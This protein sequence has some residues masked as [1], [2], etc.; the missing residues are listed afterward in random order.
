MTPRLGKYELCRKIG[1]GGMG[2]VWE[3]HDTVLDRRVALK[4]LEADTTDGAEYIREAK[5]AAKVNHPNVVTVH[6]VSQADG[7]WFIVMEYV[8]G[9]SAGQLVSQRGAILWQEATRIIRDAAAGLAAIHATGMIHRDVKPGNILIAENGIAKI[10]DFGLAKRATQQSLQQ[11]SRVVGTPYYMSPEQCWNEVADAR[12]DIYSLGATYFSLLTGEPPYVGDTA[13]AVMFA[14]C[15]NPVPDPRSHD[16]RLPTG[17]ANIIRQAM[18]KQPADR[19]KTADAMRQALEQLLM[20]ESLEV[21]VDVPSL[22]LPPN[23]TSQPPLSHGTLDRRQLLW[24][25]PSVL[26]VAGIAYAAWR[27]QTPQSDEKSQSTRPPAPPV[28]WAEPLTF[29]GKVNQI[30][31]SPDGARLAASVNNEDNAEVSGIE[32]RRTNKESL[33]GWPKQ[34]SGAEGVDFSPDGQ[35]LAMA[36][37]MW[38]RLRV[39]DIAADR[40][41]FVE[42]CEHTPGA[43]LVSFSP[44]G[45]WLAANLF[46]NDGAKV[47]F[48]QR[49]ADGRWLI[50]NEYSFADERIW[51]LR[52]APKGHSHC[53]AVTT[54][55]GEGNDTDATLHLIDASTGKTL[56]GPKS[57]P[58]R[59]WIGPVHD[60]ARDVPIMALASLGQIQFFKIPDWKEH[61]PPIR[62]IVENNP[63]E[64]GTIAISPDGRWLVGGRFDNIY[65]WDVSQNK[66]FPQIGRHGNRVN[67]FVFTNDSLG[68]FS[69]GEDG[70]IQ[71]HDLAKLIRT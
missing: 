47:R 26:G 57:Q 44:D 65:L 6:D 69:G 56:E 66:S 32:Y 61:A 1:V 60:F 50:K 67:S 43:S 49:A 45:Q 55:L 62:L 51:F 31:L 37:R 33:P 22:R 48:W 28:D 11:S 39:W 9:A 5:A 24:G 42:G 34:G 15:N 54:Y 38:Q 3:A 58:Q 59:R 70:V 53:L 68:L 19:Y 40:E 21:I 23:T 7:R 25:I 63:I 2:E 29:N 13:M 16:A 46:T 27:W 30:V 52:F 71:W 4:L 20:G 12:A 17:C 18:A 10:A 14:H 8:G 41:V 36:Y 35:F 64:L